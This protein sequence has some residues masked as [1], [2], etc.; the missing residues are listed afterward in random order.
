[1]RQIIVRPTI[2]IYPS[3]KSWD[4]LYIMLGYIYIMY[5]S[6]Q[7]NKLPKITIII[8]PKT[9]AIRVISNIALAQFA[10]V[11]GVSPEKAHTK[12]I[13]I[14]IKGMEATKIDTSQSITEMRFFS[15]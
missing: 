11:S 5:T 13:T 7:K 15:P 3:A 9:I 10:L 1:R 12:S 4:F 6:F 14:P 8:T 2:K